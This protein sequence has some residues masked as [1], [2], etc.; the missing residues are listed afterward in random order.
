MSA[1]VHF[2]AAAGGGGGSGTVTNVSALTIGTAGTNLSSTVVNSTTTPVITLNVPTA[3]AVNRGALSSADWSTFNGK[4]ALLVSGT[5]IKTINGA[6][7]LGSGDLSISASPSGVS[8]AV[9]FSDGT[10]FASDA[11]N[12]FWD[13]TNNRLGIGTNA[14]TFN[15]E[16]KQTSNQLRLSTPLDIYTYLE[17][18]SSGGQVSMKFGNGSGTT[19][20]INNYST[21]VWASNKWAF[22][23]SYFAPSAQLHIKGSGTTSATTALL[24]QNSAGTEVLKVTDDS[25]TN[26]RGTVNVLH[27][28]VATR[29]LK[30]GWGSIFAT[31]SGSELTLGAVFSVPSAPQ[32]LLAGNTRSSGA[33]TMQLQASLGVSIAASLINPS[34]QLHIKGSG[35]TSATTALLVQNSAGSELFKVTDNGAISSLSTFTTLGGVFA[36][37]AIE[38]AASGQSGSFSGSVRVGSGG[39]NNASAILD[40]VSTTKGFLPPRMTT[41]QRNAI[42]APAAGLMV[43]DTDA[44][45]LYLFTTLWEQI[46][47]L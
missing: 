12:F 5:N 23:S 42:A 43:Y 1:R 37:G 29:S 15:L 17:V 33:N 6:S 39:S 3:S 27:P 18:N 47:S 13:D 14:P 32:I 35:T 34:A 30:L 44:N 20:F 8:G 11:A 4:Q 16:V 9:Q 31:D 22:G 28:S 36:Y 21:G 26:A 46:T 19:H 40:A 25:V 2:E 7:L 24:V 41:V 38:G 45:K 10:N